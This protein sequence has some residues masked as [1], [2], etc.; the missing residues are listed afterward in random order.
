MSMSLHVLRIIVIVFIGVDDYAALS[1]RGWATII[2]SRVQQIRIN[3]GKRRS[4]WLRVSAH[5]AQLARIDDT[6]CRGKNKAEIFA[7]GKR[8]LITHYKQIAGKPSEKGNVT[9]SYFR[10]RPATPK[11]TS[12]RYAH[13]CTFCYEA[14]AYDNKS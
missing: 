2:K 8:W 1:H 7:G 12:N 14:Y 5:G 13:P 10:Y 11:C 3:P 4:N 9:V 6:G